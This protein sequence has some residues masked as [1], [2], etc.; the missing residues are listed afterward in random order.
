M[1]KKLFSKG[2]EFAETTIPALVKKVAPQSSDGSAKAMGYV[3][4]A[5][6]SVAVV[7]G[8]AGAVVAAGAAGGAVLGVAA[9]SG[10]TALVSAVLAPVL[11]AKA[12]IGAGVVAGGEKNCGVFKKTRL[13]IDELRGRVQDEVQEYEQGWDIGYEAPF[14]DKNHSFTSDTNVADDFDAAAHLDKMIDASRGIVH[15]PAK[16]APVRKR[17]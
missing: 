5:A 14:I 8:V 4:V 9:V 3:A 12:A 2:A 15:Q 1:L 6:G 11:A 13:A 17:K 7:T 16:Q 10:K